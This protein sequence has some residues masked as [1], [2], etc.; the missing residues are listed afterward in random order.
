MLEVKGDFHECLEVW[1]LTPGPPRG[2]RKTAREAV[3]AEDG[4]GEGD[5]LAHDGDEGHLG[6]LAAVA[7]ALVKAAKGGLQRIAASAAM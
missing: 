2:A 1:R 4:V 7:E 6:F 3:G 5:E